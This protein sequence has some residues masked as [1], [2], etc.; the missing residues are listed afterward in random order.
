MQSSLYG[1][2]KRTAGKKASYS[3]FY[4]D[5]DKIAKYIDKNNILKLK[6]EMNDGNVH[7]SSNLC[8]RKCEVMLEIKNL[9]KRYGKFYAVN[10]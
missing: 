2:L 1:M 8:G 4:I 5:D 6:F 7:A 3:A 9:N 10:D